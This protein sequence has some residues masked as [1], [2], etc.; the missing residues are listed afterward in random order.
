ML[1]SVSLGVTSAADVDETGA[2]RA[3]IGLSLAGH[4]QLF[5]A[6]RAPAFFRPAGRKRYT[7]K[8]KYHAAVHPEPGCPLGQGQ[9]KT[10]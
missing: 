10:L 8:I 9:A 4:F 5:V 3:M 2:N 1:A 7:I 6:Q